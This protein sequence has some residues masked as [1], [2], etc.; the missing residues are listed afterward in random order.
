M[1][2]KWR[3]WA[4]LIVLVLLNYIIFSTA[5][6]Q[7]AEQRRPSPRPTRT[8]QPTFESIESTP[9]AWIVLPTSTPHP[10]RIPVTPTPT[11]AFNIVSEL[12]PTVEL[13]ATVAIAPES[14]PDAPTLAVP[15]DTAVVPTEVPPTATSEG[16]VAVH[17][18]KR[19]ETLSQIAQGYGVTIQVIMEAN[20]LTDPNRIITGQTLVIPA[21]GQVPPTTVPRSTSALPTQTPRPQPPAATPTQIPPAPSPTPAASSYQFT[22]QITWDPLVAPNCAGPAIAKESTIRD[23]NG[24]PVDGARVEVSCYNNVWTSH[25][26]GNPG[27]YEPGHYDF[28]FGQNT[29]QEWTCTARVVDVNGQ[30]VASSQVATIQFDTNDCKPHGNGH[31]VAI[32]N[33]TKHW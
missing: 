15:T 6:T 2:M 16:P 3:H 5:F 33:W 11:A 17:T 32:L 28:A 4:I 27:E 10:T 14:P 22:A 25:P 24:N 19:G 1:T 29:P 9:M 23:A 21:P 26:S 13:S 12:T 8:L 30:P 18:I 7:L 20:E 31:Q